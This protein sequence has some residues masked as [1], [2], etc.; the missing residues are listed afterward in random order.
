MYMKRHKK[1]NMA[2]YFVLN[3]H[4]LFHSPLQNLKSHQLQ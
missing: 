1:H 3:C 2:K 4:K